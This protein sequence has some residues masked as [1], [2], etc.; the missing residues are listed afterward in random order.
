MKRSSESNK[1]E[2]E[3]EKTKQSCVEMSKNNAESTNSY[4]VEK[5]L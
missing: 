3:K 5:F 1:E 2:E 4:E